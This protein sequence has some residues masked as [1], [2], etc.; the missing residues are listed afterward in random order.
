MNI[1]VKT[2]LPSISRDGGGISSAVCSLTRSLYDMEV[3][4]EVFAAADAHS[5]EDLHLWSRTPVKLHSTLGPASF[6]FQPGLIGAL[7]AGTPS[8][9]HS[10]GIWQYTSIAAVTASSRRHSRVVSPHGMLDRWALRNS[11][12]KKRIASALFEKLNLNGAD[13]IHALC[14]EEV[15]AVR[16]FGIRAPVAMI[17]NGVDLNISKGVHEDPRWIS[18]LPDGSK[19]LLF[20]GRLHPKK[21]LMPL[22]EGM[23]QIK[24]SLVSDGWHLV[25]AGWDQGEHILELK[26]KADELGI[27]PHVHFVGPQFESDKFATLAAADAFI[28]PSQSEGLPMAILEAWAFSLPVV[29]TPECNL[30][31]AFSADAAIRVGGSPK[32]IADGLL[33][34]VCM[35][36]QERSAIGRNGYELAACKFSWASAGNAM[37]KLYSWILGDSPRPDFVDLAGGRFSQ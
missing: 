11:P 20:L 26:A 34:L 16:D 9:I 19:I 23:A 12:W 36:D 21:G 17:P 22:L 14:L 28:L 10:H 33:T 30:N 31:E 24:E 37:K 4:V 5:R 6:Q 15:K 29:M 7:R 35:S 13:C 3:D 18:S 25:I 8:V 2:L 27:I 32:E 1:K